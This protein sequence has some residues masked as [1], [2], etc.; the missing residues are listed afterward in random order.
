MPAG[1]AITIDI[2]GLETTRAKLTD[3][4]VDGPVNRFLDRGAIYIQGKAREHAAVDRGRLRN[5]IG[6]ET[7]GSR[8]RR[9]G[10]NVEYGPYV[11]FGTKPHFPPPAALEGWA[12]RHGISGGGYVVARKIAIK[13]T[14]AQPYMTPAAEDGAGFVRRQVPVLAAEVETAYAKGRG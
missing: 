10:P 1:G 4:R 13:G 5:S 14:K 11:E 12:R 3:R 2:K 7:S 9:I 8:E 6:V